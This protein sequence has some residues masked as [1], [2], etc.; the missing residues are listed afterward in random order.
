MGELTHGE[1]MDMYKG[2]EWREKR[3]MERL[4]QS[5]SWVTAPHLKRPLDPRKLLQTEKKKV[6]TN[7]EK[8]AKVLTGLMDKLGVS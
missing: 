1:L 6:K 7:P 5:A 2:Y 4:A 3:E 8:T